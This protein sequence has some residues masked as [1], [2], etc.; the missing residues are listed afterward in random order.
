MITKIGENA[1]LVWNALSD[2]SKKSVKDVKKATK[3]TDK[4]IYAALGWL[5]REAKLE[6]E[7]DGADVFVKLI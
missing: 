3:L 7:E 6:L 2:G 4:D 5:S 1:G